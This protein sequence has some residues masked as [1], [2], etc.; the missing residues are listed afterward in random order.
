MNTP[1]TSRLNI[2]GLEVQI[3]H[4]RPDRTSPLIVRFYD[5]AAPKGRAGDGLLASI[6]LD[7]V[8]SVPAMA[9]ALTAGAGRRIIP[10]AGDPIG[11][12]WEDADTVIVTFTADRFVSADGP[13][14]ISLTAKEADTLAD[15][16]LAKLL[17]MEDTD[18]SDD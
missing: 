18:Q 17:L 10:R 2:G 15:A 13:A 14:E 6:W 7:C 9:A 12:S 3:V 1:Q 5:T 16:L 4:T 11:V 8:K